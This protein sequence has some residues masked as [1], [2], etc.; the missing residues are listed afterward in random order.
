MLAPVQWNNEPNTPRQMVYLMIKAIVMDK[1]TGEQ[2]QIGDPK[3]LLFEKCMRGD[4]SDNVRLRSGVPK[5]HKKQ[6]RTY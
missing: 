3:F 2:K 5:R 1:K 4:T 6:S